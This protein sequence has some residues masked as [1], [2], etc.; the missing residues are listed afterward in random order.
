M[1]KFRYI[2]ALFLPLFLL[3]IG[4]T[5]LAIENSACIV[6]IVE[7]QTTGFNT[8]AED[9]VVVANNS[10]IEQNL[11]GLKIIYS[12]SGGNP[13]SRAIILS[14][15]LQPL[16][17][18]AF[19]ATSLSSA[20]QGLSLLPSGLAF[21]ES[22]GSLKIVDV[23][24]R[25]L[26]QVYWGQITQV[27]YNLTPAPAAER[28]FSL[29]RR[30][31][32]SNWIDSN[33]DSQDF[34]KFGHS[35]LGL[36][37][38]EIQP[39]AIDIGGGDQQIS[40]E[41]L[42]SQIPNEFTQCRLDINNR[43]LFLPQTIYEDGIGLKTV[44]KILDNG[45]LIDL[46]LMD[47]LENNLAQIS[48][49]SSANINLPI[50]NAQV[51][52]PVLTPGQSYAKF[53]NSWQP[54]YSPTIGAANRLSV[55]APTP[56]GSIEIIPDQACRSLALNEI[57]A[58][59][60]GEDS[61]NEWLEII[62]NSDQADFLNFC[63]VSINQLVFRFAQDEFIGPFAF[64]QFLSM[65]DANF[66]LKY[67]NLKNSGQN[68]LS[69]GRIE[70]DG[71]FTPFQTVAY[72][73]AISGLTWSRFS[74]GWR[75]TS[76]T[77][78]RSNQITT[79]TEP[80]KLTEFAAAEP[81]TQVLSNN[82][83]IYPVQITELLPN[84]APPQTDQNNEYIEIYNPTGQTVDISGY[85]LYSGLNL[86]YSHTIKDGRIESGGYLVLTSSQTS[87]SLANSGGMAQLVA[88]DGQVISQTDQYSDA[89][90]GQAWSLIDGGWQWTAIPSPMA[91]NQF[92]PANSSLK[93]TKTA[94]SGSKNGQISST[95]LVANTKDK[96]KP[97]LH[98]NLLAAIGI[99]TVG[100]AAYEYRSDLANRIYQFKRYRQSRRKIG[101][102]AEGAGDN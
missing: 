83:Q 90:E 67:L 30:R 59:P 60:E 5:T 32:E 4:Q 102:T 53:G 49:S 91:K 81:N 13:N 21:T 57:M 58:N 31:L 98:R 77:P 26:D 47:G 48:I 29:V 86:S 92:S 68:V 2:F 18:Q 37:I 65:L 6:C 23:Q 52:M 85:K 22:G 28:G 38:N 88:P 14:G 11:N 36:S 46:P 66:Q 34:Q 93:K 54:T 19:I 8:S 78:L 95:D 84:P 16:Q 72:S 20:N 82:F 100:Y 42:I 73:E 9:Y 97:P 87:L 76:P 50:N 89:Q 10:A 79:G 17:T 99:L 61:Q 45:Q 71:I 75:W 70:A 7:I 3:F 33:S 44:S 12:T 80:E 43:K 63:A 51:V 15:S 74:D 62:N 25:L 64:G 24:N 94:S 69:F 55:V 56:S 35:C 41:I 40:I 1:I 27:G 101:Q 96:Q 39:S